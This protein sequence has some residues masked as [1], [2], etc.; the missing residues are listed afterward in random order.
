MN[1]LRLKTR[2]LY[3]L[4]S[5]GF[6]LIVI[7]LIGFY[8]LSTMKKHVDTLYFGSL[9]PLTE[10]TAISSAYRGKLESPIYQW[11]HNIIDN[12]TCAQS[13]TIG[14]DQIDHM[15]AS[16]L[17]HHKRPE[18]MAYIDYTESQIE[19]IRQYLLEV[20]E[21]CLSNR[22]QPISL[23]VLS[24]N[25][26]SI[27]YTVNQLLSYEIAAAK[28][29]R[30]L[31]LS[32]HHNSMMQLL[33]LLGVILIGVMTFAWRIFIK[34]ELQQREL[35]QSSERL[36][37][38]NMRLEQASYTD[39]LTGLN[40]R[41]Y[42]NM[43]YER[44]LKR[45]KRQNIPFVFMMIDIDYFKQYNDTYGH[46]KGDDA[47]HAVAD[48]M[49]QT[50]QRPGDFTFRLGGEEFGIILTD[51]DCHQAKL[52]AEKLRHNVEQRSIEH[53]GSKVSKVL[54]LSIGAVCMVPAVNHTD[55]DL[56]NSADTNLYAAKER[57]R[58]QVV[59]TN[60]L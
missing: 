22:K 12:Q 2:L 52:M 35:I 27:E 53:Q 51:T 21:L 37:Y 20:R 7:G 3:L 24:D 60:T 32:H 48:T 57:G 43:V 18:E 49:K 58:N 30:S 16:Y 11:Q 6:G 46:I 47:L 41:R 17:T 9:I 50:F 29:E 5:V 40:N 42:F 4:F 25:I 14:L 55:D 13:I 54:T 59:M 1:S 38:L 10:L 45:A 33:V 26:S 8:N 31:L 15:W 44:E 19:A 56:I 34:I 36:Q 39:S 23:P 28:Y